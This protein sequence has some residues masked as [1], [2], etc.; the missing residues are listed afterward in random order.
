M[1]NVNKLT[2]TPAIRT[3]KNIKGKAILKGILKRKAQIEPVQ[4][5]VKGK[6]MA[7]KITKNS[8][9]Q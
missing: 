8:S 4:A 1:P 3:P 6:G 7:T 5:P 2:N 9:F